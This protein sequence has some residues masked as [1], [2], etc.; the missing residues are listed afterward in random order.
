[1]SS[2]LRNKKN[3]IISILNKHDKIRKFEDY[4]HNKK[5]F[6]DLQDTELRDLIKKMSTQDAAQT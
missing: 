4:Y 5:I 6:S 1:M 2:P 3:Y